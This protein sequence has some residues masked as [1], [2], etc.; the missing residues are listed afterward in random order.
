MHLIAV[1]A[2]GLLEAEP[3]DSPFPETSLGS[4]VAET[5]DEVISSEV[6]PETVAPVDDTGTTNVSSPVSE[7]LAAPV[8]SGVSTTVAAAIATSSPTTTSPLTTSAPSSTTF[9]SPPLDAT[10]ADAVLDVPGFQTE[11]GDAGELPWF[12]FD[13]PDQASSPRV[14]GV[15]RRW[16][17][18]ARRR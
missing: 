6:V 16:R 8:P 1:Y 3:A 10:L 17:R 7:E 12:V 14:G 11:Q 18:H 15:G 4:A 5:V 2:A 9:P 13:L